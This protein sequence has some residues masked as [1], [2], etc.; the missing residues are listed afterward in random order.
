MSRPQSA[1]RASGVLAGVLSGGW[2]PFFLRWLTLPAAALAALVIGAAII[3]VMGANP[4][5]GYNALLSGAFGGSYALTSTAIKAIPLLLVGVGI[6]IAFR[7][8]VLNIG[9]EGQIVMG[10]L[11]GAATAIAVPN[12]PKLVLI[13]L[14]LLAGF[15]AGGIWGAIPGIFKAYRN[16]NEV[17]STIMLNLVAVQLMNYLLA[18]PM[19]DKSESFKVVG[20]IPQTRLLS[21]N[22]W[23]PVIVP[24]TQLHLGVV[25]AVLVAAAAYVMLRRTGFG[26]RIRAVGLSP[27]ASN[28][29]GM[30][31][32]RTTAMALTLSGA[33]CGLAGAIL[34][35][36]SISHRMVTD[37]SLTGFTGSDGYYGIVVAL[38]GGL[39][40]L[41]TILSAF[42]FGGLLTG[43]V[44]MGIAL[45]VP[46]SSD[47]VTTIVGLVVC[48]VVSL[49][50]VRHRSSLQTG[51]GVLRQ[52]LTRRWQQPDAGRPPDGHREPSAAQP[53]TV[54]PPEGRAK[55]VLP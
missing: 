20:R 17:L 8:N 3:L 55:E 35:F 6:C 33:M 54:Q 21:P 15:A 22:S 10:G 52:L 31:V 12:L 41:W 51:P 5:T 43:G 53:P 1:S 13:P 27:E 36:G 29:A 7:A 26:F 9:G 50:A 34:V 38:F 24:G 32:K 4:L 25:I 48:F 30:R 40:P 18:G 39:N 46:Y 14:V 23:L 19:I 37:G 16:V 11:A 28:Y 49:D 2:R 44:S 45:N 47:L 42:L